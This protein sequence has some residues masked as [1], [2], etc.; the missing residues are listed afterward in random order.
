MVCSGMINIYKIQNRRKCAACLQEWD[1]TL[2]TVAD[3]LT[4]LLQLAEAVRAN[5]FPGVGSF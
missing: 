4:V 3:P 5:R 1:Y 2:L